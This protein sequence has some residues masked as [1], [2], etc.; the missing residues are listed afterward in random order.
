MGCTVVYNQKDLEIYFLL[1]AIPFH[2][3]YEVVSVPIF[4]EG[5]I[6][7]CLFVPSPIAWQ[8]Q[9]VDLVHRPEIELS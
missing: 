1:L 4:K 8:F 6:H 9:L 2:S 5:A 7:P 3:W